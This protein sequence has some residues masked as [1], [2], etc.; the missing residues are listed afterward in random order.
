MSKRHPS[1]I[2]KAVLYL[3][4]LKYDFL[5]TTVKGYFHKWLL[6]K[7]RWLLPSNE[8]YF[9]TSIV[10]IPGTSKIEL[11]VAIVYS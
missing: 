9:L 3:P 4:L 7:I 1:K 11:F 10:R 2:S 6:N 5:I 8:N